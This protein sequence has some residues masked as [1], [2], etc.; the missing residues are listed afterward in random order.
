MTDIVLASN[1]KKKIA[2]LR[3]LLDENLSVDVRV[4]SLR[5]IGFDGDIDEFGKSFESNSL[6]KAS[7]PAGLGYIGIADDSGL[8][9]D[10]LGGEPGIYSARYAEPF[11]EGEDKDAANRAK[12]LR[13]LDG[14]PTEERGGG[15]VCVASLVLPEDSGY[16]IPERYRASA[17][18]AAEAGVD[19]ARSATVR[20]ECRGYILEEER[21]E[22]GFGYDSL[23]YSEET[24]CSFAEATADAKNTVSH[25]G[26]AMREFVCLIDE[27]LTSK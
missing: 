21:G 12:L 15:F 16:V 7:V 25:R 1:N 27:I 20:G 17:D 2:E 4:L 5:D 26:R 24:C 3:R 19:A 14:K 6:I 18:F 13:K 8:C 22:G 9:V 23:F 10:A 11:G